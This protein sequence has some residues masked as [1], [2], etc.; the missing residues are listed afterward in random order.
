MLSV[1]NNDR[2]QVFF[3]VVVVDFFTAKSKKFE[4]QAICELITKMFSA[5][6]GI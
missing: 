1:G 6:G 3:F 5:V 2:D 4:S